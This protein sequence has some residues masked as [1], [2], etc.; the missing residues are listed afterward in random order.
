[1]LTDDELLRYSRQIL[2][3]NFDIA[4]QQALKSARVLIVGSGGLGCPVAL[5]LGA[6]GVG[7]LTLVDDD[8]IEVAN[9]QRQIAFETAQLGESKAERLADR[10]RGINPLITVD[11]IRQ[12]LE[13]EDFDAPVTQASLV[14][15]CCDNFNTRFALNRACVKAGVPLVSGAAI[16]GEGQISVYDSRQPQS[17]C[18]HCLYSEQGNEDLTCSEAGVIAPLVGMVGAAQAMEAIKVISGVGKT[19]V[20]RLLIVDAWRMEWREMKLAKD[21]AC[22]VC[23]NK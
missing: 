4:G 9:L 17:P 3:P 14:L 22:P 18:Y 5:Y 10:I 21:P 23:S 1:M 12:R 15:D 16:R 7:H 19:L 13:G 8:H 2:M 20:G 6:A 11:V